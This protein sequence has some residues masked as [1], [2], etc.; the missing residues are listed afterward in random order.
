MAITIPKKMS[1][2][3]LT[4]HGGFEKLEYRTDIDVPKLKNNEVLIKVGGAAVN[5]TDINTRIGW[6]SKKVR[7][8]T[9]TGG[10]DGFDNV[11]D[12]LNPRPLGMRQRLS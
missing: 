8:D 12:D 4:G 10:A 5:N 6:Y 3:L 2:V 1:G 9:N 11:D 7:E